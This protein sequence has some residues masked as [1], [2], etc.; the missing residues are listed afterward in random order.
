MIIS[1]KVFQFLRGFDQILQDFRSVPPRL[2]KISSKIFICFSKDFDQILCCFF[3]FFLVSSSNVLNQMLHGFFFIN[4]R[5]CLSVTRSFVIFLQGLLLVPKTFFFNHFLQGF[6]SVPPWLFIS[7][8]F[9][10]QFLQGFFSVPTIL[11][12]FSAI[13]FINSS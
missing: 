5:R 11:K 8:T 13:V 10:R 7:Y 6:W 12:I 4:P 2:K 3:F 9:F 1:F